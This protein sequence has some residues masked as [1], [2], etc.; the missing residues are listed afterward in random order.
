MSRKVYLIAG[1][2]GK[3]TGAKGF[4]DEGAETICL[5]NAIAKELKELLIDVTIDDDFTPL[6]K[7]VQWLRSMVSKKDICIDIHFNASSNQQANG[8]EIF[9]PDNATEDENALA[10]MLQNTILAVLET[11]NRGVKRESESLHGKLAMLS[12]FDCCNILIEVC[13][14]TNKE[15]AEKYN[16]NFNQLARELAIDILEFIRYNK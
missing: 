2:N 10:F 3:G 11:K 6:T 12:G 4:I 15:D 1:H 9:V 13:F 8:S 7:V 5:R 16:S 14:V